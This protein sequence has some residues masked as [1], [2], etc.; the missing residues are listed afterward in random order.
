[1]FAKFRRRLRQPGAQLF[2]R[3]T[4]GPVL[5]KRSLSKLYRGNIAVVT[6]QFITSR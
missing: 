6:P 2:Q 4:H 1:M 3:D 5:S